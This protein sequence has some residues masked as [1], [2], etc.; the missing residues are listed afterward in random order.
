MLLSCK[1]ILPASFYFTGEKATL[2]I[3]KAD[4]SRWRQAHKTDSVSNPGREEI[5]R[6]CVCV[7]FGFEEVPWPVLTQKVS[8]EK[9]H[10][11]TGMK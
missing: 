8:T 7:P 1:V 4:C 9:S 5:R 3:F 10:L 11:Y 6:C 2:S